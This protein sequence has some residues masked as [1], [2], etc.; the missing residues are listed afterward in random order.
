VT[1][2]P[3]ESQAAPAAGSTAPPEGGGSAARKPRILICTPEITE[4]PEGMGNAAHY[5]RAKGGGLG[6]ISAGLIQHLH[7]DARFE[8]HVV[9]PRYDAKIRDLA[10][11][12]YR[13]IDAMGRVLGR[14]GVHLVTDSAFSSLTDVYGE[15]EANPRIRRAEAFQRYI[16]ND[17]MPRLEPDVVHCNDWMTGLVP[18]AARAA[19]IKSLFTLHNVF[20]E[21]APPRD[22]DHSGI[23]VRRYMEFLYFQD[24]PSDTAENWRSNSID[25][26]ATGI[27]AADIV[28]TV[29][30]TFLEEIVSGR[31][32]SI[33]PPGVAH[34]MR[35]KH[36]A[37]RT[38]GILNAP[39]DSD[40]PRINPHII[41]Y[42]IAD[43]IEGKRVNKER[44]QKEMGLRADPDAPLLLWPS[45]LYSQKGPELLAAIA[46]AC[47]Q[48]HGVQIAL[49]ANGDRAVEAVFRRLA[50]TSDGRIAHRPF[51]EDLGTL[52]LAGADF[53]LM[54]SLYEPCG[55]P[56]MMGPRFGTPA[57][58][59]AT[60][61]LKDTVQPL[62]LAAH[63][64]NGFVFEAHA[65][66]ALAGAIAAAVRFYREPEDVRRHTLQ[67]IMRE[68]LE[69]FSLANTA[70]AYI[71]V[72]EKL[73]A[74]GR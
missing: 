55:L 73:I 31:F 39:G 3:P 28:N 58:A 56:Q 68:S 43:V 37:G 22:V 15:Q 10:R 16:I 48:R 67:R 64:G 5:F 2:D 47:V 17:L 35:E 7:T 70:R 50:A 59:R 41:P 26:T 45:R 11:I 25:F 63:S 65:A 66:A 23:D 69:R 18:A 71:D 40:D 13:E 52:A 34:A 44:F 29:S 1:T 19:G 12:T 8:L 27:H 33:V 36:A 24:F 46:S 42:D 57:I 9:V 49:V 54:P 38:L 14:Q 4:L 60:G 6:D 72:Y 30:P 61:G 21:H 53:V 62:D 74:E 51:R 20:T 32:G